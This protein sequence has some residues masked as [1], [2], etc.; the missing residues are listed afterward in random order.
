MRSY[1]SISPQ[2]AAIEAYLVRYAR[3]LLSGDAREVEAMSF[4]LLRLPDSVHARI[5]GR[6]GVT[7]DPDDD[8]SFEDRNTRLVRKLGKSK[9]DFAIAKKLLIS[10]LNH[11][12]RVLARDPILEERLDRLVSALRLSDIEREVLLFL[13]IKKIFHAVEDL[14]EAVSTSVSPVPFIARMT[15]CRP[16]DIQHSIRSSGKLV[17][18]ELLEKHRGHSLV[19]ALTDECAGFLAGVSEQNK[20]LFLVIRDE[21]P[22]Y[23]LP[24]F[25][26]PA[27]TVQTARALITLKPCFLLLYG[28]PGCMKTEFARSLARC[29][30]DPVL[31]VAAEEDVYAR[32]RAPALAAAMETAA[33]EGGIVIMD[34]ADYFLN[35]TFSGRET[36]SKSWLNSMFDTSKDSRVIFVANDVS[37]LDPSSMRRFHFSISFK[38]PDLVRRRHLWATAL[39]DSNIQNLVSASD[40]TELESYQTSVAG[41]AHTVRA[42]SEARKAGADVSGIPAML[43]ELLKART[44]L[45]DED[46][47]APVRR[48]ES[49]E[50]RYLNTDVPVDRILR[51][52]KQ[53]GQGR[54]VR[55]LFTGDPGTGKSELARHIA[56]TTGLESRIC[57][58]SHI[59]DPYVG[60]SEKRVR[61][62]FEEA[63]RLK[64]VLI[65]DEVDTFLYERSLTLRTYEASLTNEFLL[66]LESF[67]GIF[68]GTSNRKDALDKAVLRRFDYKVIFRP[69]RSDQ[70]VDLYRA[71][72]PDLRHELSPRDLGSLSGIT[73]ADFDLVKRRL[74][75]LEHCPS[76]TE[77]L[78]ELEAEVRAKNIKGHIGFAG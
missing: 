2:F 41:I 31:Q 71:T 67:R 5:S 32:T 59:L 69:L 54:G 22:F 51:A 30:G 28:P 60:R 15:D 62:A 50:L 4:A 35:T 42:V 7:P 12:A 40:L 24:S 6:L 1:A 26:L 16:A 14:E 70:I 56:D 23:E 55:L 78:A 48:S 74:S 17:S 46:R 36:T 63:E 58:P 72:F 13:L 27:E 21:K 9:K 45:M 65:F 52:V 29:T 66:R 38:R 47:I 68:V 25:G 10:R 3:N 39:S 33:E 43:A 75:L 77:I 19:L 34:E 64:Q 20:A 49:F 76:Q 53:T 57:G 73:P 44:M 61:E 37:S 8:E 11:Q 18:L